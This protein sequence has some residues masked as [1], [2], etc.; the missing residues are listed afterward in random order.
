MLNLWCYTFLTLLSKHINT[1]PCITI[2]LS[3]T[4]SLMLN[5]SLHLLGLLLCIVENEQLLFCRIT[6]Y[7]IKK[8][9]NTCLKT[10]IDLFLSNIF[11]S[12]QRIVIGPLKYKT[13]NSLQ[14]FS[15]SRQL[16]K[17]IID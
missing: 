2:T 11:F 17:E 5:Q 4:P 1:W 8:T 13:N 9:Q 7:L 3:I 10:K 15:N 12:S 14:Q 16:V 6:S